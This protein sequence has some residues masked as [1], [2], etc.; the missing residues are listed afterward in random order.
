[1]FLYAEGWSLSLQYVHFKSII[2]IVFSYLMSFLG[3]IF[4]AFLIHP[5]IS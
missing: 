3:D 1:M 4:I 5:L 2:R